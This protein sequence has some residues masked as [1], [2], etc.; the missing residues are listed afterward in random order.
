M[1][2]CIVGRRPDGRALPA[3]KDFAMRHRRSHSLAVIAA[4]AALLSAGVAR[5]QS[6]QM[7]D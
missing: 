2:S 4:V 7:F 3:G 1:A 5:S 6:V